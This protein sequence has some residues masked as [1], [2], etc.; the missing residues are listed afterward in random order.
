LVAG[1][2]RQEATTIC[3]HWTNGDHFFG[4]SHSFWQRFPDERFVARLMWLRYAQ[5]ASPESTRH[6]LESSFP[7]R[8]PAIL[9]I[10]QELTGDIH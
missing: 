2:A 4:A 1:R 5:Q 3:A 7:G 8:F 6:V 9:V 10:A